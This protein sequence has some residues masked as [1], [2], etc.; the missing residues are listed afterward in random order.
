MSLGQRH[1][2]AT[3]GQPRRTADPGKDGLVSG[4]PSS[5]SDWRLR[6]AAKCKTARRLAVLRG[7]YCRFGREKNASALYFVYFVGLVGGRFCLRSVSG[8]SPTHS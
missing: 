2:G 8:Q 4:Q 7:E 6:Q 3:S 1:P 5:L